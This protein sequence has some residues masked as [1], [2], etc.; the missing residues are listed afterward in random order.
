MCIR[1][2]EEI[3]CGLSQEGGN[4]RHF[5]YKVSKIVLMLFLSIQFLSSLAV[6]S[7]DFADP[8]GDGLSD[9]D[10]ETIYQTDP[11]MA[12]TDGDGINDGTEVVFW[13]KCV[14]C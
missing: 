9:H 10:E 13:R 11:A 4:V 7:A 1:V 8:D 3:L 2:A 6:S 5:L 14:V 12:D